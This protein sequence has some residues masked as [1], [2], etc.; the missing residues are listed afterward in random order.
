MVVA[1]A[2]TG[3]K[4]QVPDISTTSRGAHRALGNQTSNAKHTLHRANRNS[5]KN[6][7]TAPID[8]RVMILLSQLTLQKTSAS[9]TSVTLDP[10]IQKPQK[11]E[12]IIWESGATVRVAVRSVGNS[13]IFFGDY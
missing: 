5:G 10:I 1:A 11:P 6:T 4:V 2:P 12:V 13:R 7:E 3:V 9:V 8:T